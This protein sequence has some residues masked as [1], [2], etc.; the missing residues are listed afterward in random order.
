MADNS[1]KFGYSKIVNLTGWVYEQMDSLEKAREFYQK[2]IVLNPHS[3]QWATEL[4]ALRRVTARQTEND[5]NPPE[6]ALF[7]PKA[8]RGQDVETDDAQDRIFVSGQAKDKSGIKWVKINGA[9]A[10]KLS[11]DGY[12]SSY[13]KDIGNKIVI[14]ASDRQGNIESGKEYRIGIVTKAKELPISPIAP[15]EK[16]VF[17]AVLIACSK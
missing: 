13:L 9:D 14:Q 3:E 10:D 6:I 1:S 7:T 11:E 17:H 5:R 16:P 2:A 4:N 15:E 8:D 12:F